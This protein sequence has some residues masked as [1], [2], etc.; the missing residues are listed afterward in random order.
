[1]DTV[2]EKQEMEMEEEKDGED[3]YDIE[4]CDDTDVDDD[5]DIITQKDTHSSVLFPCKMECKELKEY[6]A[7]QNSPAVAT[8]TSNTRLHSFRILDVEII[9]KLCSTT[10][11]FKTETILKLIQ[12]GL[13]IKKKHRYTITVKNTNKK[14]KL[15]VKQSFAT[16]ISEIITTSYG[17]MLIGKSLQDRII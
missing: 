14:I 1:M 8:T 6:A 2:N 16:I 12:V 11:L 15:Y 4:F 3:D 10:V 13:D 7:D 9:F 5:G 17:Y